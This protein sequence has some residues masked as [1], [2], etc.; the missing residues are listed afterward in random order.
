MTKDTDPASSGCTLRDALTAARTNSVSGSCPAG[1]P[2][3]TVDVINFDPPSFPATL[4]P[5]SALPLLSEDLSIEGP[6][7]DKLQ[8]E[9]S[10]ACDCR[11]FNAY[12][13]SPATVNVTI[14]GLTVTGGNPASGGGGGILVGQQATMKLQGVAVTGNAVAADTANGG[15][16][17]NEGS[18]EVDDSEVSGNT[19]LSS[20]AAIA[21]RDAFG[22]GILST[23]PSLTVNNS[24][25]DANTSTASQGSGCASNCLAFADG[26]GIWAPSGSV[27]VLRSTIDGNTASATGG[28]GA[29]SGAFAQAGGIGGG[30][31]GTALTISRSTL[32]GNSAEA[33]GNPVRN[34]ADGGALQWTTDSAAPPQ[35][36]R[37]TVTGNEVNATDVGAVGGLYFQTGGADAADVTSSTISANRQSP[38][39][40]GIVSGANLYGGTITNSIVSDP[41]GGDPNCGIAAGMP[42]SAGFNIDDGASCGFT[43]PSEQQDTDPGLDP[44]G[45]ADNGGPT[46]TIALVHSNPAVDAGH[47]AAGETIDQRGE[48]RPFDFP[49]VA[50]AA[51]SDGAD[52]GAF[53]LLDTTAPDTAITSGPADG[54]SIATDKPSFGFSST[55]PG[56]TFECKLDG[57]AY[58]ACTSPHTTSS[59]ADGSH[60]FSVRAIDPS[61]NVDQ[62]PAMRTFTVDTAAPGVTITSGPVAG[63]SINV[64]RPSFGFSAD[65]PGAS[66]AC[67]VDSTPFAG[68]TGAGSDRLPKLADGPHSFRVRATDEAGNAGTASR[69]FR[70]DTKAPETKLKKKPKRKSSRKR[71]RLKF[72]SSEPGSSFQCQLDKQHL[73]PC[74]SPLSLK[75]LKRGK[76]RFAVEAIDAAGNVDPSPARYRWRVVKKK[77]HHHRHHH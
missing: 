76:H 42:T 72:K 13:L 38:A 56:S 69:S 74:T 6:G 32:S 4:K 43:E 36:D 47:A 26:A 63:S 59:L 28:A 53:E 29:G 61:D 1:D 70:V 11:I 20:G 22:G 34:Q 45:L 5:G 16:I 62:T 75:H 77:N 37:V 25:I 71:A 12:Q 41:L 23:G 64:V 40:S 73:T 51:G 14:S 68:C 27:S 49:D 39:S 48:A 15:G 7:A 60:S 3:P 50:N 67:S 65:E 31:S 44:A 24:S 55:E 19:A 9:P 21:N 33:S 8:I 18:L 46:K 57:G 52:V 2:A 10:A 35:L 54:A 30:G 58:E 66:V 17:Y